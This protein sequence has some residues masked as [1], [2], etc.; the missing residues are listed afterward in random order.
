MRIYSTGKLLKPFSFVETPVENEAHIFKTRN[1]GD[2]FKGRDSKYNN[3][4]YEISDNEYRDLQNRCYHTDQYFQYQSHIKLIL[5]ISLSE[6][7]G[8]MSNLSI[9]Q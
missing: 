3:T 9:V 7:K 5:T 6:I 8:K 4:N 2:S 1:W